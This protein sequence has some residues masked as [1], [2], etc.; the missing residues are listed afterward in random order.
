MKVDVANF[1]PLATRLGV[2]HHADA[3]RQGA[4]HRQLLRAEERH[5]GPP[6]QASGMRREL[7]DKIVRRS[8][9]R[10]DKVGGSDVIVVEHRLE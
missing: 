9:N 10:R 2:Q 8:E 6:G 7:A 4:M 1:A 3:A 5:V